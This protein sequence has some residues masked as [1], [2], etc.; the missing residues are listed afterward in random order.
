R[1]SCQRCAAR[2]VSMILFA[3][4]LCS[5]SVASAAAIL[6][7][8]QNFAVLGGSTVTNTGSTSVNGDFGLW[9]GTSITGLGSVTLT[10]SVHQTNAAPH[11][12][13]ITLTTA[14]TTT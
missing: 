11:P 9:P 7:S 13:Q 14:T 12:P 5:P 2:I 8:A 3:A 4:L 10:G 1:N 6:G